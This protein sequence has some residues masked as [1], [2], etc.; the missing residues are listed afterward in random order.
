MKV[1]YVDE[2]GNEQTP[3]LVMVGILVDAHRLRRA[4]EDFAELFDLL[5]GYRD[6]RPKEL[7][8][9]ERFR[10]HGDAYFRFITTPGMELTNNLAEQALRFV[11]IQRRMTQGTRGVAAR[12]SWERIWTALATGPQQ[13]RPAFKCLDRSLHAHFRGQPAPSLLAA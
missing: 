5:S 2:S 8:M 13:G 7:N 6:A 9:A 1:C 12:A 10:R 3:C 11:V 4:R